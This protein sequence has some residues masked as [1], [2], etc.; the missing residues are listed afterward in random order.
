MAEAAAV[1]PVPR[2]SVA[3]P[4]ALAGSATPVPGPIPAGS[5]AAVPDVP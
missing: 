4:A 1:H 5:A 2:R 3:G